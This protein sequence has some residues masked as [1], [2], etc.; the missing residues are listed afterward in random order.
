MVSESHRGRDRYTEIKDEIVR[1]RD[2]GENGKEEN[3][4]IGPFNQMN[5]IYLRLLS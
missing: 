4:G 3:Y 5:S 2:S 1:E